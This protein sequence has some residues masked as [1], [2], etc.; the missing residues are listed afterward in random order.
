MEVEIKGNL[1][2]IIHDYGS[3]S[4]KLFAYKCEFRN[5]SFDMVDHDEYKWIYP[6]EL[7]EFKLA[8]A[9]IPI[10]KTLL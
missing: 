3:F 6:M 9:D 8:P 5:A 4:I 10:A 7:K 1:M 2:E